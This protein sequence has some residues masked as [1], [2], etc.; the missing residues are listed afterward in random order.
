MKDLFNMSPDEIV[1]ESNKKVEEMVK[2][3]KIAKET[4]KIC[5]KDNIWFKAC[6][7]KMHE[8]NDSELEGKI[9]YSGKV[10][11]IPEKMCKQVI[12]VMKNAGSKGHD[13]YKSY[14]N[15]QY[16]NMG[17]GDDPPWLESLLTAA[18]VTGRKDY[19]IIYE[20]KETC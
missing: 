11:D 3:K 4:G 7:A 5:L 10:K 14:G 6:D 2:K 13:L 12:P 18:E 16:W 15:G 9:L 20:K 19:C 8:W 17:W 1:E